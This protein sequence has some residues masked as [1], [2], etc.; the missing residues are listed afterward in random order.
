MQLDW[1]AILGNVAE[2]VLV[3]VISSAVI[4]FITWIKAKKQ[5]L[6]EKTK[7]ET[8]KKYLE[9]LDATVQECVIATNQTYVTA[10]KKAG[11]F[12]LEEQKKAFQLTFDAVTSV[13]SDEAKKYLNEAVKDV[14]VYITNKIEAY[15][16]LNHQ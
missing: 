15:V 12:N 10:L 3:P 9:M 8:I 6:V 14:N 7:N 5:E 2:L 11:T 1:E 16:G 13:L 4:Y